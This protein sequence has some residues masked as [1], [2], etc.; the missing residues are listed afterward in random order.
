MDAGRTKTLEPADA[1]KKKARANPD[2]PRRGFFKEKDMSE[3]EKIRPGSPI[4]NTRLNYE[5]LCSVIR[6][7]NQADRTCFWKVSLWADKKIRTRE[8][9]T[10]FFDLI[11]DYAR[12][13]AGPDARN[14]AA[15]F[16][17]ILKKELNYPN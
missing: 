16:M 5:V 4:A 15:V 13:A 8:R 17:S 2:E 6:P 9:D 1:N 3:F 10:K 11:I 14:P 12:E 7:R